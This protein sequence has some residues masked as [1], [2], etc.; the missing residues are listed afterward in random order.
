MSQPD[1]LQLTGRIV[2]DKYRMLHAAGEGGFAIVYKA[3]HV[4]WDTPVA[5]KIFSG[6]S[7]APAEARPQLLQDFVNEGRLLTDLSSHS[8]TIVQA[9]DI[10]HFTA[11]D[12]R[13]MPYMVLEWLEGRSLEQALLEEETAPNRRIP[14]NVDQMLRVIV[15][16][17]RALEIAHARGVTHRD[18][19]PAN[20]FVLGGNPRTEATTLKV[21][22]FGVAKIMSDH[23]RQNLMST[24]TQP[25]LRLLTPQYAAPE[26]YGDVHGGTG[27]WTD[28][29]ALALIAV[30]LLAGRSALAGSSIQELARAA[31]A[32]TRPTPRALG[33]SVSDEIEQILARALAVRPGERFA[34]ATELLSALA[35]AMPKRSGLTT[36]LVGPG[37]GTAAA[38][39]PTPS[40]STSLS[41]SSRNEHSSP[42]G[43]AASPPHSLPAGSPAGPATG[44]STVVVVSRGDITL[45]GAPEAAGKRKGLRRFGGLIAASALAM[46]A[47]GAALVRWATS[48][49]H[50]TG[51]TEGTRG[52]L[53]A[54]GTAS[55]AAI[56]DAGSLPGAAPLGDV[57]PRGS[58]CPAEMAFIPAGQLFL[59]SDRDDALPNEKPVHHAIVTA[60]CM[61][62]DEV[63]TADYK[64]CSDDGRCLPAGKTVRW[65]GL[66]TLPAHDVAVYSAECNATDSLRRARHPINCVDWSM[67]RRYCEVHQKRLPTEAEWEYAARG[68]DGRTYPWGDEPPTGGHLN[69]CGTECLAWHRAKAI[70]GQ[71]PSQPLYVDNDGFATT[72][73]VGS[74]PLGSSRF[75]PRDVVGNVW[76]WVEDWFGEYSSEEQTD[77]KGPSTGT[78]KV[79][80][81]GGFNG[82]RASWLRPSFRYKQEPATRSW[83]VGFRCASPTA[84]SAG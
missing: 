31:V 62:L 3:H 7:D 74:F 42:H 76:E 58:P 75:G 71:S 38:P 70:V 51:G 32:S 17:A 10:G 82:V 1:P 72:A 44:Q 47:G 37:Q 53:L 18:M 79:M 60:F 49:A 30:E 78:E 21:L 83:G 41:S 67:A 54:G 15:P 68:P 84:R 4:I 81:G 11:P 6:L 48:A 45:A 28:V 56:A 24:D 27:P 2:G 13:W 26:Q 14:W 20:L 55:V 39:L 66:E 22:D 12:G 65:K 52:A 23:A 33:V 9:R 50:L 63:S 73:P 46:L 69:A 43:P 59:G 35:S 80:R 29:F 57:A 36:P 40:S 77:P 5:I 25:G 64:A 19:K 61:D 16:I 8:T 34:S